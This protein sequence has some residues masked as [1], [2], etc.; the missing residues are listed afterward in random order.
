MT[1]IPARFAENPSEASGDLLSA[2]PVG[3]DA[4]HIRSRRRSVTDVG[5]PL[6]GTHRPAQGAAVI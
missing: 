1:R 2:A 5:L 4:G 3:A 6:A